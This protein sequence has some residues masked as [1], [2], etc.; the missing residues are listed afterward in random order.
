MQIS[1]ANVD[2]GG[3]FDAHHHNACDYMLQ[4]KPLIAWEHKVSHS[5]HSEI[6]T[7]RT[8]NGF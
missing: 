4:A 8:E 2:N 7:N 6:Q 5:M 3:V 1:R